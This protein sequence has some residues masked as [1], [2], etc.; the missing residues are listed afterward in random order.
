M[1]LGFLSEEDPELHYAVL[2][3][4]AT[5][6]SPGTL[7]PGLRYWFEPDSREPVGSGIEGLETQHGDS[8]VYVSGYATRNR[9]EFATSPAP[10]MRV[11][12][13]T[14]FDRIEFTP[15]PGLAYDLV[16]GDVSSLGDLGTHVDLGTVTCIGE[17]NTTG[18][19]QDD[20][21]PEDPAV[22]SAWFYLLR[23]DT[24]LGGYGY[25][26]QYPIDCEG[27]DCLIARVPAAGDCAAARP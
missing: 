16:R 21:V 25:T 6:W 19:I 17:G 12:E 5:T 4:A 10:D 20:A 18:S 24:A 27:T 14:P 13:D 7:Y 26:N 11:V 3:S 22:G 23:D 15:T 2:G 8:F 1:E 9:L